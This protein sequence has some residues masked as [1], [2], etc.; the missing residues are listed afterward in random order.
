MI[1][2]KLIRRENL[3]IL[4]RAEGE[5]QLLAPKLGYKN[6]SFVSHMATGRRRIT[7][8]SARKIETSLNLPFGWMDVPRTPESFTTVQ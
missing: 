7:E 3:K 2:M 4:I 5:A 1:D 8:D 6:S